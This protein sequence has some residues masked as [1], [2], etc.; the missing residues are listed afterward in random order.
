MKVSDGGRWGA[1]CWPVG[2]AALR[3]TVASAAAVL[4]VRAAPSVPLASSWSPSVQST[5]TESARFHVIIFL[6]R[7]YVP[8]QGLETCKNKE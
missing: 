5:Q 7:S 6:I 8:N 2:A 4:A 1:L 3:S